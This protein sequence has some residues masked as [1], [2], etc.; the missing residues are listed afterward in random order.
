M[1]RG[2]TPNVKQMPAPPPQARLTA[3]DLKEFRFRHAAL[4]M[5]AHQHL[6]LKEAYEVWCAQ[7]LVKYRVNGTANIRLD[8]G[9]IIVAKE[10][11]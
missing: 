11:S 4:Q 10:S 6:M 8:N 5:S 9:E 1:K 3:E 2:K 7:T